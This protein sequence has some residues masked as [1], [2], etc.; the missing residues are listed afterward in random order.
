VDGWLTR[1]EE[2]A[3]FR[4]AQSVPRDQ[5]IVELGSWFGRSA[6]LLG[7]G[8]VQG[9]GARVYAVDLFSAAGCAK[10]ILEQR[11]GDAAR[12]F[13]NRFQSNMQMAGLKGTVTPIR[14]A[15]ADLGKRWDGPP[16]GFLFI[17]ADHSYEGVSGD[18]TS[19]KQRLAAHA[20]IAF[21]DYQN[22]AYAEVTR[23][24]DELMTA[25][26]LG[27]VERHDSILCG[28]VTDG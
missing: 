5:C 19:W 13:L 6:I 14:S 2:A 12:D 3:L 26:A 11:A 24:V 28:E 22:P 21:H 4:I 1:K 9:K 20:L 10:E 18:W 23:F 8:S 15:T 7:G 16:I 17:D 25:G 27:S